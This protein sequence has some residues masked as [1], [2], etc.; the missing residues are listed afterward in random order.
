MYNSIQTSRLSL[1]PLTKTDKQFILELLNSE[2]WIKFIGNR[3]VNSPEEAE[4][5]IQKIL[6]K[7]DVHYWIVR[8]KRQNNSVGIITLIK[9][10]YLDHPDIGFAFL[11]SFAKQ[12]F[13]FEACKAVLNYLKES[14]NFKKILA[15]TV[16][17]NTNS[18]R[19]LT[20]LG[21][22]FD[23]ELSIENETLHIYSG[24][25]S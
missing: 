19:L 8:E 3:N 7:P 25:I 2:G 13:A 18:I 23:H 5:Y 21:L 10:D 16:P 12:G 9:R 22:K 6:D 1:D 24:E 14:F 15:T 11:P 17:A 4:A 20:K